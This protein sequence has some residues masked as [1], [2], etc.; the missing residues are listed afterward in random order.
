MRRRTASGEVRGCRPKPSGRRRRAAARPISTILGRRVRVRGHFAS[1]SHASHSDRRRGEARARLRASRRVKHA[2]SESA[3]GPRPTGSFEPNGFGLYDMSGNVWEWVSDWYELYYYGVSPILNP[4]GPEQGRY[5]V[6]RGGSWADTDPRLGAVYSRNYTS[7]DGALLPSASAACARS[8]LINCRHVAQHL[9][10]RSGEVNIGRLH[11][12]IRRTEAR[13]DR[14]S[15]GADVQFVGT[16]RFSSSNQG[17]K[18]LAIMLGCSRELARVRR[19]SRDSEVPGSS[20]Q[21]GAGCA[22]R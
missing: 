12:V 5:K 22:L 4:R 3:G 8:H 2:H 7:P 6:I 11:G 13:A 1:H 20:S 16:R 19:G 18:T 10:R 9:P 14:S 17:R 15:A 21:R